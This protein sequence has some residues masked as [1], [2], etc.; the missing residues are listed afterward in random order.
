MVK[1]NIKGVKKAGAPPQY[2]IRDGIAYPI[3]G[4]K[5]STSKVLRT[6]KVQRLR[7]P[8]VQSKGNALQQLMSFMAKPKGINHPNGY[9]LSTTSPVRWG[10]H[11]KKDGS[12]IDVQLVTFTNDVTYKVTEHRFW[13]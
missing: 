11:T 6:K 10:K 3:A 5:A 4:T 7:T 12:K 8:K 9:S 2:I 13:K 1:A